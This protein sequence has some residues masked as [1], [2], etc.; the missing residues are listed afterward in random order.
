MKYLFPQDVEPVVEPPAVDRIEDLGEDERIEHESRQNPV[1]VVRVIQTEDAVAK[2]AENEDR[3]DLVDRLPEDHLDH[4]SG[5]VLF[6]GYPV[7]CSIEI[8]RQGW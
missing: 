1:S 3:D 5:E 7:S 2:E 4:I 6:H 8:P